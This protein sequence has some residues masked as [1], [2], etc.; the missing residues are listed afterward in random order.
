MLNI[1]KI[2]TFLVI[3]VASLL[4]AYCSSG[5][6]SGEAGASKSEVQVQQCLTP[7]DMSNLEK[8]A[9]GNPSEVTS[10][11]LESFSKA[12]FVLGNRLNQDEKRAAEECTRLTNSHASQCFASFQLVESRIR[13]VPSY[14]CGNT[15]TDPNNPPRSGDGDGETGNSGNSGSGSNDGSANGKIISDNGPPVIT[16]PSGTIPASSDLDKR[17]EVLEEQYNRTYSRSYYLERIEKD[18]NTPTSQISSTTFPK[19]RVSSRNDVSTILYSAEL[20]LSADGKIPLLKPFQP[21]SYGNDTNSLYDPAFNGIHIFSDSVYLAF[22]DYS[23]SNYYNPIAIGSY[24]T[25]IVDSIAAGTN[26]WNEE[27]KEWVREFFEPTI[28]HLPLRKAHTVNISNPMPNITPSA[29]TACN[30]QVVGKGSK[31]KPYKIYTFSQLDQYL[32]QNVTS[33]FELACD[34]DA[35][36]SASQNSGAGFKPIKHFAGHLDG[37]GH[38]I[39]NLYINRPSERQVGLFAQILGAKIKNLHIENATVTGKYQVGILAGHMVRSLVDS[40]QASGHVQGAGETGGLIGFQTSHFFAINKLIYYW[41]N[42]LLIPYRTAEITDSHTNVL[43]N[44]V[45]GEEAKE[46]HR[47]CGGLVGWMG[48]GF[49]NRSSSKGNVIMSEGPVGTGSSVVE[50][51]GDMGGGLVGVIG[52]NETTTSSLYVGADV[53]QKARIYQSYSKANV[54]GG[55]TLGGLVGASLRGGTVITESYS[56]NKIEGYAIL[57]G[58][59][60]L[61]EAS[62]I[63]NCYTLSSIYVHYDVAQDSNNYYVSLPAGTLVYTMY[64]FSNSMAGGSDHFSIWQRL[65]ARY[66]AASR[67]K[68][69]LENNY[70]HTRFHLVSSSRRGLV[71]L[72]L[73]NSGGSYYR[74]DGSIHSLIENVI[75]NYVV[76]DFTKNSRNQ[77]GGLTYTSYVAPMLK[78][79]DVWKYFSFSSYTDG[80]KTYPWR[81]SGRD[82]DHLRIFSNVGKIKCVRAPG[83]ACQGMAGFIDW[84]DDIWAFS[85]NGYPSLENIE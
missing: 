6:S 84:S 72:L 18:M 70:A 69:G 29:I 36:A 3:S 76:L 30:H 15:S 71:V 23:D 63:V 66:L 46:F 64:G 33:Y 80:V 82:S 61:A 1:S 22:Y 57:G 77:S 65:M 16:T 74:L 31:S 34:I 42:R 40:V 11:N 83:L 50:I 7:E 5:N 12:I 68:I 32:R 54:Y 38:T 75:G 26:K 55:L 85:G 39:Q 59:V 35:S 21:V 14:T 4:L 47:M 81:V 53:F 25:F 52:T 62:Y 49:V 58:L 67:F 56:D 10:Q 17:A 79:K 51:D 45:R 43:V 44:C 60:A 48:S 78:M 37:K 13:E 20:Q 27:K 2:Y 41:K 19:D 28:E 9:S 73:N 8:L 24:R